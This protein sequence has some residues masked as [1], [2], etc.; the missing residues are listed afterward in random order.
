MPWSIW[1]VAAIILAAFTES[2]ALV[3]AFLSAPWLAIPLAILSSIGVNVQS[4]WPFGI[5]FA[6][7]GVLFAVLALRKPQNRFYKHAAILIL[8]FLAAATISLHQFSTWKGA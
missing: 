5:A 4:V 2:G 6:A 7:I 3:I 8:G 1:I